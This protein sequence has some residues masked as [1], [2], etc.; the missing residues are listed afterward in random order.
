M[1]DKRGRKRNLETEAAEKREKEMKQRE[2]DEKYAKW[3]KGLVFLLSLFSFCFSNKFFDCTTCANMSLS[4]SSLKQVEDHEEK[5]KN[6]LYEM[7][8][9]LARYAD[10]ADLDKELREQEREGDPMLEYIKQK[11]I[12]EG[13]RKP[14][15]YNR[16]RRILHFSSYSI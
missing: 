1:R 7:H 11:Q 10:D 6:D 14:G 15:I 4:Y 12:K 5:L 2:I 13:K 3:G 9:P 16:S 8:K